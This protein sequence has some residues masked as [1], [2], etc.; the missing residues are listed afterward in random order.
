MKVEPLQTN[1]LEAS[2]PVGGAS[3][4]TLARNGKLCGKLKASLPT[5]SYVVFLPL[6]HTTTQLDDF[7]SSF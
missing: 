7:I 5:C 6:P 4:Q 3:L 2:G 1:L